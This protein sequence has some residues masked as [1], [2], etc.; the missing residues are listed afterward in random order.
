[1]RKVTPSESSQEVM[2]FPDTM[3]SFYIDYPSL[4]SSPSSYYSSLRPRNIEQVRAFLNDILPSDKLNYKIIDSTANVGIDAINFALYYPNAEVTAF[5]INPDTFG[6]LQYNIKHYFENRK[7][8]KAVNAD[9]MENLELARD[10]DLV[11]IDAPWGDS[12]KKEIGED[13]PLVHLFLQKEGSPKV[14]D[15]RNILNVSRDLLTNYNVGFVVLKVPT[16]YNGYLDDSYF[17]EHQRY[18]ITNIENYKAN[19]TDYVLILMYLSK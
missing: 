8:V 16:N 2:F 4:R 1:M 17:S 14:D 11:Y 13:R 10:A 15:K 7:E 12:Y 19:K 9:F 6:A 5:E 18:Q 3:K